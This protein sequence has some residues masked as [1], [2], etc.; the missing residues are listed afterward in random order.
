MPLISQFSR[1]KHHTMTSAGSTFSVPATEDFTDGSWTLNDLCLS[2][3]GVNE[4]DKRVYMRVGS[5]I[6]EFQTSGSTSSQ[7]NL[8]QTLLI[9]NFTGNS[10]IVITDGSG[11]I[12]NSA[13]NKVAIELGATNS[14]FNFERRLFIKQQQSSNIHYNTSLDLLAPGSTYGTLWLQA[15]GPENNPQT[16]DKGA[17]IVAS[18]DFSYFS[19]GK[20]IYSDGWRFYQDELG[21][22]NTTWETIS[23][24]TPIFTVPGTSTL[25]EDKVISVKAYIVGQN[26]SGGNTDCYGAELYGVFYTGTSSNVVA[27]IGTPSII[28]YKT[29]NDI[30][31]RF[32]AGTNSLVIQVQH[33]TNPGQMNFYC[34]YH[35]RYVGQAW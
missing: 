23:N 24:I 30:E 10:N 21:Y 7:Q 14:Y 27:A 3:I 28:E 4:A 35:I 22:G 17:V 13:N 32:L 1:I 19:P 18:P 20:N 34:N 29:N 12:E 25:R 5:E 6:I 8:A 9:G 2:E 11:L 33:T 16:P 15:G 26:D 31:S